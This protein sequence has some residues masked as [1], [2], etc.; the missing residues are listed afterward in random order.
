MSTANRETVINYTITS[1]ELLE[2]CTAEYRKMASAADG[3]AIDVQRLGDAW[4]TE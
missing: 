2:S 1:G 3:H 4:M